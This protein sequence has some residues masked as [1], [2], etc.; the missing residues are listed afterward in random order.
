L[1]GRVQQGR[2][3]VQGPF[4]PPACARRALVPGLT[5]NAV[6]C[7][8]AAAG[9]PLSNPA[10]RN[11]PACLRWRPSRERPAGQLCVVVVVEAVLWG[12]G[13]GRVFESRGGDQ[14]CLGLASAAV[15][16][17]RQVHPRRPQCAFPLSR[18]ATL[19]LSSNP[20]ITQTTA[21]ECA[22][23]RLAC[24]NQFDIKLQLLA[25]AQKYQSV[26]R[27]AATAPQFAT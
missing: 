15:R 17:P 11:S 10:Q 21:A 12:S 23:K 26:Q 9:S 6:G 22:S 8:C 5:Q 7:V 20:A 25:S 13:E 2:R 1:Q 24:R 4:C 27:A 18:L 16:H 3:L 19:G 14:Y